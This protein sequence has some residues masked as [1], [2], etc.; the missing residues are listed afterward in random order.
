MV[1]LIIGLS[2]PSLSLLSVTGVFLVRVHSSSLDGRVN[3]ITSTPLL[4]PSFSF[5]KL[6]PFFGWPWGWGVDIGCGAGHLAALYPSLQQQNHPVG[7][8][9]ILPILAGTAPPPPLGW[10]VA[11]ALSFRMLMEL[12]Q[13]DFH[14]TGQTIP[15]L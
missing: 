14:F 7:P 1:P 5:G 6:F 10:M 8:W 15:R 11:L 2:S 3:S 9:H 13:I 12:T 4:P